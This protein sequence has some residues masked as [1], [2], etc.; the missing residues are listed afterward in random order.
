M[1][2]KICDWKDDK[3]F[4]FIVEENQSDKVFFHISDIE[5]NERRPKIGD[6]VDFDLTRDNQQ[7]LKAKK[8]TI[9]GLSSGKVRLNQSKV[10]PVKKTTFDYVAI[11][12]FLFSISIGGFILYQTKDMNK[13]IPFFISA[14]VAVIF[15]SRQKKPKEKNFTCARCKIIA[16]FDKRTI[17]AWN[18]GVPKIY[19]SAC[20]Q[21]W[22]NTQLEIE[23]PS[24]KNNKGGCLGV[25][26]LLILLPM[27]TCI[28][29]S[30]LFQA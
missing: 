12:I 15:F 21:Q 28:G 14:L 4:G 6:F 8:I 5:T 7:R 19:C 30:W 18:K 25:F 17:Q 26:I 2:G 13:I 1:K 27:L 11:I 10:E 9:K 29:V 3:G 23:R 24:Q 16:E 22:V 20:H